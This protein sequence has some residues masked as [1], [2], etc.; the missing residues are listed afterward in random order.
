MEQIE[1][2]KLVGLLGF[3]SLGGKWAGFIYRFSYS[4]RYRYLVIVLGKI[5]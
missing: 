5:F 3:V 1:V 2:F 4:P